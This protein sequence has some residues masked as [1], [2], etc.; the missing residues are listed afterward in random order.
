M[1]WR[2]TCSRSRTIQASRMNWAET[3]HVH[4]R[5]HY[6]MAQS[7]DRLAQVLEAAASGAPIALVRESIEAEF[8]RTEPIAADP[9]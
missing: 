7:I 2:S 8:L 5:R 4:V 3:P 9:T 6:T 1:R